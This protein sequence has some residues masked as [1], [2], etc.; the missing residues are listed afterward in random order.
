MHSKFLFSPTLT[1]P[2][3][4]SGAKKRENMREWKATFM[5]RNGIIILNIYH[6]MK[7]LPLIFKPKM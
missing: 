4:V 6:E 3:Y 1:V 5:K 7:I 2:Y